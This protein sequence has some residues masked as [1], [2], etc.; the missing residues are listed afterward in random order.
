MS[1]HPPV[2]IHKGIGAKGLSKGK[3]AF[4]PVPLWSYPSIFMISL[5]L[6]TGALL[7]VLHRSRSPCRRPERS[8]GLKIVWPVLVSAVPV[9]DFISGYLYHRDLIATARCGVVE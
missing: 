8:G 5:I 4:G 7:A 6:V 1:R 9:L 2:N 3:P